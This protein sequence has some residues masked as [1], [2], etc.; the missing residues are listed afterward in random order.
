MA[1]P[2][3]VAPPSDRPIEALTPVT[4]PSTIVA[5]MNLPPPAPPKPMRLKLDRLMVYQQL[6][7]FTEM[8]QQATRSGP[9]LR[10][11]FDETRVTPDL[12][13]LLTTYPDVLRIVGLV[14]E[15][16]PDTLAVAPIV[17][18]LIDDATR[19][20]LRFLRDDDPSALTPLLPELDLATALEEWDLPQFL[21]FDEEWELVAQWGPRPAAAEAQLDAWLAIPSTKQS[22]RKTIPWRSA[23]FWPGGRNWSIPCALGTTAA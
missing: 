16:D 4:M 19:W 21:I 9:F 14:T 10:L 12:Q 20:E 1:R 5:V 23:R 17:A 22:V 11:R 6:P 3:S 8:T 7:T 2:I 15:E 18:R 13:G